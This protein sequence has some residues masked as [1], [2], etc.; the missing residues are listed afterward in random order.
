[1]FAAETHL[2]EGLGTLLALNVEK[3]LICLVGTRRP[4]VSTIEQQPILFLKMLIKK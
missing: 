3:Y 1:M 4:A 2:V